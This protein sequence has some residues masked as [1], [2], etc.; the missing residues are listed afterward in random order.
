MTGRYSRLLIVPLTLL[1]LVGTSEAAR[2][3]S[4]SGNLLIPDQDDIFFFPQLVTK[5]NRM[6]TFDFGTSSS[7]GSG[8][9]VFGS[10]DITLGAF[11][12]RSDFI[13]SLPSAFLTN[14]D[15][16][17]I[18]EGGSLDIGLGPEA[19]N[20]IDVLAGFNVGE[21]PMGVRF[22][23]GRNSTDDGGTPAVESDVTALNVI[24]GVTLDRFDSDAAAE[25]SYASASE[26]APGVDSETSPFGVAVGV[27][28][29]AGEPSDDLAL[30]WL[31]MFNWVSGTIEDAGVE[32]G[33]A[34]QLDVVLGAG[35]IYRPNDRT[36]VAMYGTFEYDRTRFEA[37]TETE[38]GT[39]LTIPGWNIAGE[40]EL[41][42]WC[43]FRAGMRSRYIFVSDETEDTA[44]DP[45]TSVNVKS[46]ELS[47]EWTTGVGFNVGGLQ[48]DAFLNPDVITTG[49]DLLGEG[50]DGTVFGMVSTT[51][52]F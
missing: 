15:I 17:N 38:T 45:D 2:R 31:G 1:A 40:F 25:F 49:T 36:T 18:G 44:P 50:G 20:W 32:V 26:T 47:F 52:R 3:S 22:S 24:V 13:G 29:R 34:N 19:L 42:S 7:L 21:T 43:Q 11:T 16:N 23:L 12:H 46:N 41:A 10:E 39:N 6:V 4:L 28:R 9:L 30:G 8:G 37:G 5:H 27:R 51:L 33:D 48:I 14:G 35:P